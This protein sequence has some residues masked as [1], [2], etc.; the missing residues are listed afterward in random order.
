MEFIKK[1]NKKG[2]ALAAVPL[3]ALSACKSP[4]PPPPAEPVI[5]VQDPLALQE[6][7]PLPRAAAAAKQQQAVL[8]FEPVYASFRII[9]VSEIN[10]V[11][12][13]FLV[14]A[15]ADKTGISVGAS[16]EVAEDAGFQKIIGNYKIVEV[17]GD[18][19]RGEIVELTHRI[20]PGA[21]AR[22]KTGEQVKDGAAS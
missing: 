21:Y 2:L 17:D 15:G 7:A 8:E 9:E 4:P 5:V 11:Q 20:G 6:I 12:K 10:G 18:F 16:G 22:V 14:K 3:A 13:Y 1:M 19:F